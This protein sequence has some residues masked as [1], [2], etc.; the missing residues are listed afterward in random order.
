MILVGGQ[1]V[2]ICG[3]QNERKRKR[4]KYNKKFIKKS[5]YNKM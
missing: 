5:C 2:V 1:V 4:D 3:L